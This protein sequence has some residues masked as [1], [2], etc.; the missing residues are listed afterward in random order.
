VT[1]DNGEKPKTRFRSARRPSV[2]P[3][4]SG[5]VLDDVFRRLKLDDAARSFRAQRAYGLCV[6]PRIGARSRAERLRGPVLHVRV[7]TSA[8]AHELHALKSDIIGKLHATPGG[9][10]IEDLRFHVAP[11]SEIP[12]WTPPLPVQKMPPAPRDV[13]VEDRPELALAVS[14]VRD[15]ELRESLAALFDIVLD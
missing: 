9:E 2:P 13:V 11:L 1:S 4:A 10:D 3:K 14:R 15:P 5:D 8:W 12:D 6:G 7:E